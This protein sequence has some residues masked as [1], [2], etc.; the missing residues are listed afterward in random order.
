MYLR[1]PAVGLEAFHGARCGGFWRRPM[2][3][4]WGRASSSAR[5]W[6]RWYMSNVFM[7]DGASL[8][9]M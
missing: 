7:L 5:A 6:D 4:P 3:S 2:A 9:S 1:G 8:V